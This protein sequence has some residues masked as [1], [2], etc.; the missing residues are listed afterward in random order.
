[1]GV[2]A[3]QTIVAGKVPGE[4]IATAKATSSSGSIGTT[5]TV[6]QTIVA[7]VVA[8]RIYK[9]TWDGRAESSVNGDD[10]AYKIREDS[11]SGTTLQDVAADVAIATRTWRAHIEAE[12]T[13]D[14]TE[15]KTF[16][17]TLDRIAGSGN[18]TMFATSTQPC[19]LY[20]DYIRDA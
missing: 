16:V 2:L 5:E 12:Y 14:V 17:A 9:I 4:R 19:F 7:P 6:V 11:V 8:G 18:V 20:C 13:A 15:D 3:G 10:L 1:M